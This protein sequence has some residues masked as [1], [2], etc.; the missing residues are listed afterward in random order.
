LIVLEKVKP[1]FA[2]AGVEP[3]ST[4]AIFASAPESDFYDAI[5]SRQADAMT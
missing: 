4:C 1:E 5:S 3:R 2:A